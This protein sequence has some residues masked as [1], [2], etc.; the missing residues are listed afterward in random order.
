MISRKKMCVRLKID[1]RA[2]QIAKI[3]KNRF[4]ISMSKKFS[5][6][7]LQPSPKTFWKH[8]MRQK[9]PLNI[10]Q[11]ILKLLVE[12]LNPKIFYRKK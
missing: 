11:L 5:P 9:I 10:P 1:G 4:S 2:V 6:P 12:Y 3:L 8:C 7:P